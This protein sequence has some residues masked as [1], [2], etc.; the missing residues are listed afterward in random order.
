MMGTYLVRPALYGCKLYVLIRVS[1]IKWMS[2]E[3]TFPCAD[4]EC[5]MP[6]IQLDQVRTVQEKRTVN[7]GD[8]YDTE[9]LIPQSLGRF[10]LV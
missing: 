8:R 3:P 4:E 7:R 6:P 5:L 10:D 9:H 2:L 1:C